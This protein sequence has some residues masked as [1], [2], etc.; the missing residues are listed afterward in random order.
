M[1]AEAM[2]YGKPVITT[3]VG[4]AAMIVNNT[5]WVV[6]PRNP[7]SLAAAIESVLK[8]QPKKYADMANLARQRIAQEYELQAIRMRYEKFLEV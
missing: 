5:G 1:V 3:D 7:A 4:D 8:M 6:P 2:S